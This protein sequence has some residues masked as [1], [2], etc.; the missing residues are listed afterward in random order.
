MEEMNIGHI[1]RQ[2]GIRPSALRYYESIGLLPA[3]A[4]ASGRR[5]YDSAVLQRL[6]IIHL[7]KQAGFT[8][9]EIKTLLHGFEVETPPSARWR[10]LAERKLIEVDTLI[11][12]AQDM[13]RIL[14]EGLNCGCLSFDDC[15]I[16]AGE[17]CDGDADR[18]CSEVHAA[19]I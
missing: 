7:A 16:V 10:S 5:R 4:R 15:V 19:S 6:D 2:A 12:R 11:R 1:A 3:P 17:R 14:E 9:E 13:K 18:A 8:V